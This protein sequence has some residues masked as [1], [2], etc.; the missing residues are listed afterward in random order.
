MLETINKLINEDK[1]VY[2]LG[3]GLYYFQNLDK[4]KINKKEM[5]ERKK[6]LQNK[7]I[8]LLSW[9]DWNEISLERLVK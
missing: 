3:C 5:K 2:L 4:T 7:N 8:H 1:V 9:D 6:L